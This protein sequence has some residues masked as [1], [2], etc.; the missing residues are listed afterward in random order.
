MIRYLF[1]TAKPKAVPQIPPTMCIKLATLSCIKRILY[2]CWLKYST[3]TKM[4]VIGIPPFLLPAKLESMMSMNTIPDAPSNA[5]VG[6]STQY[7]GYQRGHK[8]TA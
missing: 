6:N 3:P 8:D 2:T 4:K 5:E 1:R 7:A